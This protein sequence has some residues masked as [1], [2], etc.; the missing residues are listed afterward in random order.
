MNKKIIL[1]V[2]ILLIVAVIFVACKGNKDVEETTESTTES[3]TETTESTTGS[4]LNDFSDDEDSFII[5]ELITDEDES[6][7]DTGFYIGGATDDGGEAS[8]SWEEI[9]GKNS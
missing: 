5:P 3:T 1:L 4:L 9:V 6:S 7:T 2:A 8:I